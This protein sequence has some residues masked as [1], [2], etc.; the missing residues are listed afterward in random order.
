MAIKDNK[1]IIKPLSKGSYLNHYFDHIYV[2]NLEFKVADRLTVSEH[3]KKHGVDFEIFEATNG[4]TGEPLEKFEAYKKQD[5]GNLK[6]YPEYNE[7]EKKWGHHFI[8][9]AGAVGIIYSFI[10]IL[11]D[12]KKKGY[13]R[14]L[15]LEDDILLSE[16]FENKFKNFIHKIGNDWKML[17]LGA[18]QYGWETTNIESSIKNSFYYP[19]KRLGS[20]ATCGTFATGV[21]SSIIDELIEGAS[22][23]ESPFDNFPVGEIYERYWGKCFVAYPNIVMP[24]VS[25]SSIRG[26]RDQFVHSKRMKWHPENFDFPLKKPSIAIIITGQENLKYYSNFSE[27]K[28]LPF[29]MRLFFNSH[30]GLQ[31]L[32]N[33]TLLD[34]KENK[35]LPPDNQFFVPESDYFVTIKEDENLI[36]NDIVKFIEY[37][38]N[39][40]KKNK[41]PLK[42]IETYRR[43]IKNGR[44]SV[45]IPV[46]KQ[47]KN[48]KKALGSIVSQDYPSIE[49]IIVSD[50]GKN[51]KLEEETRQI[52]SSFDGRNAN[53]NVVLLEHSA[54]K[55]QSVARNIGIMNSTGEYI[56]FLDDDSIYLPHRLSM[57]IEALKTTKKTVGAVYCGYLGA[58]S[59]KNDLSRYKTG[60]LTLELLLLDHKKHYLHTDTV[61]YKREAVLSINGFDESYPQYQNLEFNLR[62]FQQFTV[63]AVKQTLVKVEAKHTD[64]DN[65]AYDL[66]RV[67]FK[68]KLLSQFSYIIQAYGLDL[69]KSIYRA[70]WSEAKRF[71]SDKNTFVDKISENYKEGLFDILKDKYDTDLD[72]AEKKLATLQHKYDTDLDIAGKNHNKVKKELTQ[73]QHKLRLVY[74][75]ASFRLGD[76]LLHDKKALLNPKV[77][78]K[79][80][81]TATKMKNKKA[82]PN[83]KP[84]VSET[85]SIDTIEKN[86]L[87]AKLPNIKYVKNEAKVSVIM[88]VFNIEP[89][90]EVSILSVLTQSHTH[91]ELI[92]VNDASTDN[93]MDIINKY[94]KIDDR[95]RVVDLEFNTLGGAGIPSNIGVDIATGEYIAYADSDDILDRYAIEKMC[96]MANATGAEVVIGDFCNFGEDDRKIVKAYDKGNW[97]GLPLNKAFSPQEHPSIFRLSPVPWRKMY[98]RDFLNKNK[99]RFPE[100]DYFFED[101]PL[102]W[103]T[104]SKAKSVALLDYVIAYHRM[105]REGQTM[106]AANFKLSAHFCHQNTVREFFKLNKSTIPAIYWK[107]LLDFSYRSSWI[108]EN[109]IN[110]SMKNIFRKR[111]A[112]TSKRILE[113]SNIP[114]NEVLEMRPSFHSKIEDYDKSLKN[115]DLTIII[116]IYN[117]E[118]LLEDTLHTLTKFKDI[119][120]EVLLID[121]GSTDHSMVICE[122]YASKYD[123]FYL[124]SQNNKGAGSA[125]NALIPMATGEYTY[126]LD[127]DDE[128]DTEALEEAVKFARNN[129]NDLLLF[130][131]KIHFYE[132]NTYCEMFDADVKLWNE[133]LKSN[134]NEQKK[135]L[136]CGM[137]NYPWIRIIKTTLLHDENIYF[138]KTVVHNDIPYHWHSIVSAKNIGIFDKA[139][140]HHRKFDDREQITNIND[141]RRM[142]VFEAYRHTETILSKYSSFDNMHPQWKGFIVDLFSWAKS[143]IPTELKESFENKQN[144]IIK[145]L[146]EIK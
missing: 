118:D 129:K 138:G 132:K 48:L 41:T 130:K 109:Q 10:R 89:Y 46:G 38:Q 124:F 8:E 19:V 144:T 67:E 35:I 65:M 97:N 40:R 5:L 82:I 18:S 142:M 108:I 27:T 37:K 110:D 99:I 134:S 32:H 139:V 68:Q 26:K 52:V 117:C 7:L 60:D 12:A 58:D 136:S 84:T 74:K 131:Y 3:L 2:I 101:N 91:L 94:A 63:E 66:S 4:Y 128:I 112:Q 95:V 47:P 69:E 75:S 11:K 116:P 86:V 103:F 1:K 77:L 59:Q 137:I 22:S 73:A 72:I 17:L 53:C 36:E 107:E 45:I 114:I 87:Q 39:I 127:S 30:D 14:F 80:I 21:D 121:D 98:K 55:N 78:L 88:P 43:K 6:R 92:I 49:V 135:V 15:I 126:F 105:G 57:S 33:T 70:H 24:D 85:E 133:L 9:S 61:T 106:S 25:D 140:C 79:K 141:V 31:P 81:K 28:E 71:I 16:N 104:I 111:Y 145:K 146:E 64:K 83:K 44:V 115:R 120:V 62:F 54:N 76:I 119:S 56:C 123:N 102:H 113:Q 29:D 23:F 125:R 96:S 90:L 51:S 13:K 34:T 20:V 122:K 50:N 42:E 100:G 93:S 143:R